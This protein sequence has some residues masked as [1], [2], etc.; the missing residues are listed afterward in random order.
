[1]VGF[2]HEP[3]YTSSTDVSLPIELIEIIFQHAIAPAPGMSAER[4]G[5]RQQTGLALMLTCRVFRKVVEPLLYKRV[6]LVR[7]EQLTRFEK[8]V[9]TKQGAGSVSTHTKALWMLCNSFSFK[10]NAIAKECR[11]VKHIALNSKTIQLLKFFPPSFH[12]RELTIIDP[13]GPPPLQSLK[14]ERLHIIATAVKLRGALRN[15]PS[16]IISRI[17]YFCLEVTDG[18]WNSN[19]FSTLG[20]KSFLE[21]K[22]GQQKCGTN[23]IWLKVHSAVRRNW[24]PRDLFSR[25][26]WA[27]HAHL[28]ISQDSL[29]RLRV[30]V[31]DNDGPDPSNLEKMLRAI[32]RHASHWEESE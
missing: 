24:Q 16:S 32:E 3:A 28:P 1:M 20:F 7:D 18:D 25:D 8:T 23:R 22:D 31:V 11:N 27:A 14:L 29:D 21:S 15:F 9:F 26:W 10:T 17:P 19:I 4:H 30:T 12:L 6:V 5:H 13:P 2:L